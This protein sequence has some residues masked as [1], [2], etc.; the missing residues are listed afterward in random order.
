VIDLRQAGRQNGEMSGALILT[1]APG[2]GKSSVLDALS[3]LLEIERVRFGA[4][5]SEQL[6]RGYPWL[7]AS[8]WV[9]QLAAVVALQKEAGRDTFLV[10]ATTE[11]RDQLLAV[12]NAV[13]TQPVLV[14]C[15]AAS[16]DI[17][18]ERVAGREPDSWPGKAAL[19]DH[20]RTLAQQ[21]PGIPN[22]DLVIST[23]D[24]DAADVA[25][26]IRRALWDHGILAPPRE[27]PLPQ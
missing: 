5:E 4:V 24:R 18:A 13:D 12:V 3:T 27:I 25:A 20:A 14:V 22:I 26:E 21:I 7:L 10:V 6:A 17:A 2:S 15:L 1:G 23:V 16:P 9:P 11:D 8:E 19:V